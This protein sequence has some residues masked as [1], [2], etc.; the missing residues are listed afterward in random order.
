MK[1][2]R[3]VLTA[4]LLA[5]LVSVLALAA[6]PAV[7]A[8][9][10][11]T[12]TPTPASAA[13]TDEPA[14]AAAPAS[15]LDLQAALENVYVQASPSVVSIRTRTL[16]A[17][18]FGGFGTLPE[19][20]TPQYAEGLGSGF[21]WDTQGHIVTPILCDPVWSAMLLGSFSPTIMWWT[22]QNASR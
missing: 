3:Y 18:Q 16:A 8:L 7:S 4:L 19:Q 9:Q 21:V 12:A 20:D 13:A 10:T 14:V 1:T 6:A 5:G 11:S 22:A 2:S 15:V 17:Q